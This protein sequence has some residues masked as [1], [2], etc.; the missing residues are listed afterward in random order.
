[1]QNFNEAEPLCKP[2]DKTELKRSKYGYEEKQHPYQE[3]C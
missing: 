2:E 3:R 1:M